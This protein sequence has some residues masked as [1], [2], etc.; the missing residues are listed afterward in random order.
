VLAYLTRERQEVWGGDCVGGTTGNQRTTMITL[1]LV[2]PRF[3]TVSLRMILSK[4]FA[5]FLQIMLSRYEKVI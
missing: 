3:E 2:A 5:F 1:L 4:R